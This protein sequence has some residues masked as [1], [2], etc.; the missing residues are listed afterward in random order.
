MRV[1]TTRFGVVEVDE[2]TLVNMPGGLLGFEDQ[3]RYC[4]IQHRPSASF[5]WLQSTQ[6][7]SLAFVVVDP[8]EY[9]ADY[10]IELS[11]RDVQRLQLSGAEDAII[12]AILTIRDSGSDVSA[13]LAAP[14]VINSKNFIA[15]QVVLEDER[16][17]TRHVLATAQNKHIAAA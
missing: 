15:Y 7:P 1:E 8:S 5:R 11:D 4:L 14:I 2:S 13:N 3:T 12:L 10:E 17:Q 6:D 9:F 16:Y